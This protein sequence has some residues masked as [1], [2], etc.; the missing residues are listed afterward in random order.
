MRS[1]IYS[2]RLILMQMEKLDVGFLSY[3]LSDPDAHGAFLSTAAVDPKTV[4]SR[5]LSG[6]YWNDESKLYIVKL[7]DEQTRIGMFHV[8]AKPAHRATAMYTIQIAVVEHRNL[9]YGTE[10]QLAAVNAVF[11]DA[12]FDAVE[13]YT[14]INNLAEIRCLEKLGFRYC[15][16]KPYT[17]MNVERTGNLYRLTRE[18]YLQ[19]EMG[20]FLR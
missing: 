15:E 1:V 18:E 10:V 19:M 20:R 13:V 12:Q 2:E 8:W 5:F 17:D 14:D 9:G 11:H 16:S 7:K 6:A 3:C 4:E